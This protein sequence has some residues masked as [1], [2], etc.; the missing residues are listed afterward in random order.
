MGM[1]NPEEIHKLAEIGRPTIA[2]ITNIGEAHIEFLGSR[3][4]IFKAKIEIL[5]Y[6]PREI[7]LNGDDD[8][9]IKM[10]PR[11]NAKFYYL[12]RPEEKYTAYDIV[13]NNLE[14][15]TATLK[16]ED[17]IFQVDIPIPGDYMVRNALA[18]AIIGKILG[19]STEEIRGALLTLNRLNIVWNLQA[20]TA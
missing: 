17:E 10:K 16:I 2:L 5:D 1:N 6:K 3:E 12:N 9:L 14:G 15:T 8:M 4:N 7:I 11:V 13:H 18:G 20:K 19:L